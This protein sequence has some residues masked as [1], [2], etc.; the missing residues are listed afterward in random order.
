MHSGF[1]WLFLFLTA[2]FFFNSVWPKTDEKPATGHTNGGHSLLWSTS[3]AAKLCER[4]RT[5]GKPKKQ[6]ISITSCTIPEM[7]KILS[8]LRKGGGPGSHQGGFNCAGQGCERTDMAADGNRCSKT[9]LSRA[10]G[11]VEGQ[12]KS[13]REVRKW[14]WVQS[15]TSPQTLPRERIDG[16]ATRRRSSDC[17]HCKV[18]TEGRKEDLLPLDLFV[19]C[20]VHFLWLWLFRANRYNI[21]SG[22]DPTLP[23]G[24]YPGVSQSRVRASAENIIWQRWKKSTTWA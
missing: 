5:T 6:S 8:L 12:G 9:L 17:S 11:R 7:G 16:V 23:N 21:A 19:L 3:P 14:R 18:G 4:G 24:C 2:V 10:L 1:H 22:P 20:K 13:K 15:P